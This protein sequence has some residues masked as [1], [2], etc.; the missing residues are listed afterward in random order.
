MK[1]IILIGGSR[2]GEKIDVADHEPL[3]VPK[4]YVRY[5]WFGT[6]SPVSENTTRKMICTHKRIQ[7][8][9]AQNLAVA[10]YHKEDRTLFFM[11]PL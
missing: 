10:E 1:Q 4:N 9:E 5:W 2:H 8:N 11:P 7:G 6:D 3:D